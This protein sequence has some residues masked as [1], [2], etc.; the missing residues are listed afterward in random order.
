MRAEAARSVKANFRIGLT[1]TPIENSATDLWAIMD[2]IAPGGLI[3]AFKR[4]YGTPTSENMADLH[5][6]VF[7][8]RGSVRALAIRLSQIGS[9]Q[10]SPAQ[11]AA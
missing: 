11:R 8:P 6:I 2:Q 4:C 9:G 10:C 1:G 3:E 7:K 5:R